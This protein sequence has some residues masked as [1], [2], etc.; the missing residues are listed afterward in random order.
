MNF[1]PVLF[2]IFLCTFFILK[3]IPWL[4]FI[5]NLL[6][7]NKRRSI[8]VTGHFTPFHQRN[9]PIK[10]RYQGDI[11]PKNQFGQ[12]QN[13]GNVGVNVISTRKIRG[14]KLVDTGKRW[15][16]ASR[17]FNNCNAE[18]VKNQLPILPT[19]FDIGNQY[20]SLPGSY[21]KFVSRRNGVLSSSWKNGLVL[22][23]LTKQTPVLLTLLSVYVVFLHVYSQFLSIH[24]VGPSLFVSSSLFSHSLTF[25]YIPSHSLPSYLNPRTSSP[26][27][28]VLPQL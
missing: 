21:H 16:N 14:K 6:K 5:L 8:Y 12:I 9:Y 2:A 17:P 15:F 18:P 28:P 25:P 27:V 7:L 19:K 13:K 4:H 22:S 23:H 10:L 26:K 24:Y 11:S 3:N 20:P 1:S